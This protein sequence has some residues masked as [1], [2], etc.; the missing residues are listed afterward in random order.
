MKALPFAVWCSLLLLLSLP[1]SAAVRYVRSSATGSNNGT[2]WISAYRELKVAMEATQAGDEIW[3]AAGTY[4]PDFNPTTGA[5][6]GDRS[7][8]FTLKSGVSYFGGFTGGETSRAQRNGTLNR[9]ILSGDIGSRGVFA[10]NTRTIMTG[11]AVTGVVIEGFVFAG[12][13]ANDPA[14]LGNGIV[15]GSGGAVYL[16]TSA[17][18][19]RSCSFVG[20]YAVYGGAIAMEPN[21]GASSTLSLVNC[22]LT[23][24]TA[25]YRGGAVQF[26][27][28]LGQFNVTNCTIV[29]NTSA[30]AAALGD[31]VVPCQFLNNIIHSNISTDKPWA[32]WMKVE[33]GKA[34]VFVGSNNVLEEA[35]TPMGNNNVVTASP[36]FAT[37]PSAGVDGQWGTVD[38]ILQATLQADSPA[39]DLSYAD[40]LPA[41]LTDADGDGNTTERIPYDLNQADRVYNARPDAGA[42][43]WNVLSPYRAVTLTFSP[44]TLPGG[45]RKEPVWNEAGYHIECSYMGSFSASASTSLWPSNGTDFLSFSTN[46]FTSIPITITRA[47]VGAF[48]AKAVDLSE[49]S[50]VFPYPK[51]VTFV[52]HLAAGET[53]A[54][55][56]TT[57]GIMDGPGGAADFQTFTFPNTFR[58]LSS[59]TISDGG[60]A[61]DNLVLAAAGGPQTSASSKDAVVLSSTAATLHGLVNSQGTDT[62]VTFVY[63]KIGGSEHGV[64]ASPAK[65]TGS[66]DTL[67]S[68]ALTGLE[69][70]TQYEFYVRA[71]NALGAVAGATLSFSTL[72]S[73]PAAGTAT[74]SVTTGETIIVEVPFD[75]T[76]AD[77]DA[78]TLDE[79]WASENAPFTVSKG[80][81]HQ[82]SITGAARAAGNGQIYFTV[83]DSQKG[84]ASGRV[85][86]G[87]IDNDPPQI[88]P[89]AVQRLVADPTG[90][91]EVPDL[92]WRLVATDNIG[93]ES[94][95]QTPAVGMK[96]PLGAHTFSFEV[97]DA[98][99]NSSTSEVSVFV[100]FANTTTE[101]SPV[102]QPGDE[103]PGAGEPGGPPAGTVMGEMFA[104][105]LSDF[106]HLVVR[107]TLQQG[108]T[109]LGGIYFE[110]GAGTAALPAFEG[111]AA[112]G[113]AGATF[114]SFTDPVI[115]PSG[116]LAFSA[117]VKGAPA[118]ADRGIWTTA[119]DGSL[120]L[121]LR[122]GSPAPGL[123][124]GV[125][126][127]SVDNL[128]LRDHEVV[129]SVSLASTSKAV[130]A[131][132][133]TALIRV[134]GEGAGALLIREGQPFP[135]IPF[136]KIKS[137]ATLLPAPGSP[138]HGRWQSREAI[139][140]RVNLTDGRYLLATIPSSGSP[141]LLFSSADPVRPVDIRARWK[142]FGLPAID[143]E[144]RNLVLA[145]TLAPLPGIITTKD[146]A[147]LL[148]K[149]GD[150]AWRVFARKGE[151]APVANPSGAVRYA[152]FLDPV[153]NSE[154]LVAFVATLEG[155]GV[156][157]A[158]K[159]A[160]FCGT[161]DDIQLVARTGDAASNPD[162]NL[163]PSTWKAITSFALPN[164]LKGP[165]F[166]ATLAKAV[167]GS[168]TGLWAVDSAGTVRMLLRNATTVRPDD[169]RNLTSF[170]LL[171]A[172]P[173][174]LG[175][176]RSFNAT[177]S[178]AV[179]VTFADHTPALLRIDIP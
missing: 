164:S 3:V 152:S 132:D 143:S 36:G 64:M 71:K 157:T 1:A 158:N 113:I 118:S 134:T 82:V 8:R 144:G 178:I 80:A 103:V 119:F 5:H 44:A 66:S 92:A 110:N 166:V 51:S 28:N 165:V 33:T 31:N 10:D 142:S 62:D 137:F 38:D 49:Y 50:A 131:G 89:L 168:E 154:G 52:G 26:Q 55:T 47:D 130:T 148:S 59:I 161:P 175:A 94:R 11:N 69:P 147:V 98:A 6:T 77:G 78:V 160:L 105:A 141:K 70:H 85:D 16:V 65:A 90:W 20:N 14:E 41:D 125:T 73:P 43:E 32:G 81:G 79:V 87:V 151:V 173:P 75:D 120:Q 177:G 63:K 133:D 96:L 112:P 150:E 58:G 53:V 67:V 72:N 179:R 15:G 115:S 57:D 135:G 169:P 167:T 95:A 149:R 91:A 74:A 37:R 126:L 30:R 159:T 60:F 83:M 84:S 42:F 121:A 156:N 108:R 104:P 7:L 99:G 109:P 29:N 21:A 9:T 23:A 56:F 48:D 18:E 22:L 176:T 100:A 25:L 174:G 35:F 97:K 40:S 171:D 162:G 122:H 68:A 46:Q 139:L 86:I 2:S 138:G 123:P 45:D 129:A 106:R 116:N 128:V 140:A 102:A 117:R 101:P 163:L 124:A 136:T 54:T 107:A 19:F 39:K 12:G 153:V 27:A 170:S 114:A 146:N 24:N 93:V 172:L 155:A 13:N 34:A 61:M 4:Y 145:A 111:M 76:D 127:K 88:A 17:V